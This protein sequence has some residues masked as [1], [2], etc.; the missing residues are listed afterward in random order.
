MVVLRTGWAGLSEG[1]LGS[2]TGDWT[3]TTLEEV[4]PVAE[5]GWDEA[6]GVPFS[7]RAV[8]LPSG[9]AGKPRVRDEGWRFL[10]PP[11]LQ[12]VTSESAE[13]YISKTL[14]AN[15]PK[16][17]LFS[18]LPLFKKKGQSIYELARRVEWRLTLGAEAWSG[19]IRQIEAA[20]FLASPVLFSS[21]LQRG[22]FLVREWLKS[23]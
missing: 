22:K 20:S 5:G 3:V 9:S 6:G 8:S 11:S 16:R 23:V 7:P 10:P 2:R 17:H 14:T 4:V 13:G 19:P 12:L 1:S 15:H 21:C 18:P